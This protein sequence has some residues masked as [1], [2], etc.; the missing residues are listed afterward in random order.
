VVSVDRV[1]LDVQ[2]HPMKRGEPMCHFRKY[3]GSRRLADAG[4]VS[5]RECS[6]SWRDFH[7]GVTRLKLVEGERLASLS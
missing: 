1:V 6:S 7:L 5:G 2:N 4:F 3:Q